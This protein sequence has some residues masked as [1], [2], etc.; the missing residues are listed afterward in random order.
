FR[1]LVHSCFTQFLSLSYLFVSIGAASPE[2]C[3]LSLHDALPIWIASLAGGPRMLT[4][5]LELGALLVAA[6]TF[7]PS[8]L[9]RLL[10]GK[11]G[12]G[13]LMTIAAIGAVVLGQVEEA[14]MLAFRD[15]FSGGVAEDTMA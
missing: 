10:K 8:T 1:L 2:I 11:I 4:L 3:T 7:V 13:T 6:W 14:A 12:V 5:P 15:A 9:R